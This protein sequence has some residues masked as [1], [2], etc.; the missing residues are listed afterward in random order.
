MIKSKLMS[1][2]FLLFPTLL[3]AGVLSIHTTV[4][5]PGGRPDVSAYFEQTSGTSQVPQA[6]RFL[7]LTSDPTLGDLALWNASMGALQTLTLTAQ[8]GVKTPNGGLCQNQID[9]QGHIRRMTW[10]SAQG[11]ETENALFDQ[12]GHILRVDRWRNQTEVP[13][14]NIQP[15]ICGP[16]TEHALNIRVFASASGNLNAEVGE[17]E[18]LADTVTNYALVHNLGLTTTACTNQ[19][20]LRGP[21]IETDASTS[22]E[23]KT[24]TPGPSWTFGKPLVVAPNPASNDVI[25][26]YQLSGYFT[27]IDVSIYDLSGKIQKNYSQGS[28]D[29]GI[30]QF[31]VSVAGL[32]SGIYFVS[33]S[34]NSG[35]GEKLI[36]LFKLAIRH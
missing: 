26:L 9:G 29:S 7:N 33:L 16:S 14:A 30:Y 31:P 34:G 13:D 4:L 6:C 11:L 20:G 23:L 17:L 15:L 12:N 10:S 35:A 22:L 27:D 24:K 28:Q 8:A 21:Q 5:C 18:Y 2:S 19:I 25:I 1:A 3:S 32:S 36:S